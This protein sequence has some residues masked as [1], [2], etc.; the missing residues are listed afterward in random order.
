MPRLTS[1]VVLYQLATLKDASSQLTKNSFGGE[2]G[3][4]CFRQPRASGYEGAL[5]PPE[6]DMGNRVNQKVVSFTCGYVQFLSAN[7]YAFSSFP[8]SLQSF[9]KSNLPLINGYQISIPCRQPK[10]CK[11]LREPPAMQLISRELL[12]SNPLSSAPR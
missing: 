8:F 3:Y 11:S 12:H 9:S 10:I 2:I 4:H 7:S 5:L 1:C 6:A